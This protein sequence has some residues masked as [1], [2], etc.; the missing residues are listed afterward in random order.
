MTPILVEYAEHR[1]A[2]PEAADLPD[3]IDS[4]V[5]VIHID[6]IPLTV[7]AFLWS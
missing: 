1:A 7:D 4:V 2:A 6:D 3:V 5:V